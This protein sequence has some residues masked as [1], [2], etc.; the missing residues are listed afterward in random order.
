MVI[1]GSHINNYLYALQHQQQNEDILVLN[2]SISLMNKITKDI[3]NNT[4]IINQKFTQSC[5]HT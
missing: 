1:P 3:N 4:K 2:K 5:K